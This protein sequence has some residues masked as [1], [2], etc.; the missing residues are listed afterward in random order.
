MLD[1]LIH[2]RSGTARRPIRNT[3]PSRKKTLRREAKEGEKSRLK[4]FQ[5]ASGILP[6]GDSGIL[7]PL[8]SQKNFLAAKRYKAI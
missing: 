5:V 2:S 1:V 7:P 6:D 4:P 3:P 8:P